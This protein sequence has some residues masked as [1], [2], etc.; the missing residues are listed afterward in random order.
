[1]GWMKRWNPFRLGTMR[2]IVGPDQDFVPRGGQDGGEKSLAAARPH[3]SSL[4]SSSK[5]RN[6]VSLQ[7]LPSGKL[8]G[9]W[10]LGI[11]DACNSP[12]LGNHRTILTPHAVK[13]AIQRW[14]FDR[15]HVG[16][17]LQAT[18]PTGSRAEPGSNDS[19]LRVPPLFV[20]KPHPTDDNFAV[21]PEPQWLPGWSGSLAKSTSSDRCTAFSSKWLTEGK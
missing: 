21:T 6:R 20:N 7:A 8:V 1:M 16:S 14:L 17:E 2:I 19:N 9:S 11:S 18:E 15:V 5:N 4:P 12:I 13:L 3:K 10:P